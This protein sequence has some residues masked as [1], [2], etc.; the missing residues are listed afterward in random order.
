MASINFNAN[1][2]PE[3]E[4]LPN[5]D[6]KMMI[7]ES[8]IIDNKSGN[9][10][11]VDLKLV[12]VDGERKNFVLHHRLTWTSA[13]QDA[14]QIGRRKLAEICRA[15]GVMSPN[16]T[17]DLHNITFVARVSVQK[18]KND[19]NLMFNRIDKAMSCSQCRPSAPFTSSSD[20]DL[21]P[22]K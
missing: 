12:V 22:W 4:L 6:Y 11:H 17:S 5:G 14:V 2:V 9:G 18:D 7:V 1:E 15:V 19:P 20:G 16:D 10:S 21:P 3:F 8:D 13:S